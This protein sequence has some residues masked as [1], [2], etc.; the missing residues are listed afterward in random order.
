MVKEQV[1]NNPVYAV[2]PE[3][4]D[5][6]KSRVLHRNLL[7]L[8]ND[9]LVE[10]PPPRPEQAPKRQRRVQLSDQKRQKSDSSDSVS[11]ENTGEYWFRFPRETGHVGRDSDG[12]QLEMPQ[13]SQ[14]PEDT[15]DH[16][17]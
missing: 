2:Y 14:V 17:L 7:L 3:N 5:G 12:C 6:T 11:N 9:L 10:T 16:F 8:V 1:G 4:S 15:C 13:T